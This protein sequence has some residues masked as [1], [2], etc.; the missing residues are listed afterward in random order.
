M[1][2]K[3]LVS[4]CLGWGTGTRLGDI[5]LAGADETENVKGGP[6]VPPS[7]EE[8]M[9]KDTQVTGDIGLYY[10]CYQLSRMGWNAMPTARNARGIDII[11]Y[12]RDCS[13]MISIQVKTLSKRNP[14]PLGVSLDKVMG[15]YWVIVNNVASE[16]QTYVLLPKEVKALAHRGEKNNKVS[17]WLQPRA[18]AVEKF[19]EAWSRIGKPR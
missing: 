15:D 11:A 12:N 7:Q 5:D 17:Y 4:A 19:H 16:P 6:K 8:V 9:S 14:V 13:R 2:C 3:Y 1:T 10:A 18:Y